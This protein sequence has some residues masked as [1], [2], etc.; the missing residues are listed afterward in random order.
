MYTCTMIAVQKR[1]PGSDSPGFG[2]TPRRQPASVNTIC[3]DLSDDQNENN[4]N[5]GNGRPGSRPQA[6]V[7]FLLLIRTHSGICHIS[8]RAWLADGC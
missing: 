1:P 7:V 5:R 2:A 3:I 4:R 6:L 8:S